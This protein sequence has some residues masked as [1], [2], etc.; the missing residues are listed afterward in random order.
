MRPM[1][2]LRVAWLV[3]AMSTLSFLKSRWS[4]ATVKDG[5]SAKEAGGVPELLLDPVPF[6]FWMSS[7][8]FLTISA[9]NLATSGLLCCFDRFTTTPIF[10]ERRRSSVGKTPCLSSFRILTMTAGDSPAAVAF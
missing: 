9:A 7:R 1:Q 10:V 6:F 5:F 3:F 2:L 8:H 4:G